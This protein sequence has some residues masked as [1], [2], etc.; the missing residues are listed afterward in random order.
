MDYPFE[1]LD[2][3]KFQEF[4][5]SL[6]AKEF[7][8]MQ[9]FPVAQPDGGR[10]A[11]A[12]FPDASSRNFVMFQVKFVRNPFAES[13]PHKWLQS[14]I[15][16]EL[17]KIRNQITKGAKNFVLLTNVRGTAHPDSG[18][19]DIISQLLNKELGIPSQCWWRDDLS[20]RLDNSWDLKWVHPELMT[21]KDLIRFIVENGLS[22]DKERRSS[23]IRAFVKD[24]FNIEYFRIGAFLS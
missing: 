17:P 9:C 7:S 21:G 16:E 4:C 3:E 13:D 20:R 14:K 11:L 6:L 8:G 15:A 18:S 22:E 1:N 2:P 12:Y 23:A 24:Q 19:I 5:Q 10:D